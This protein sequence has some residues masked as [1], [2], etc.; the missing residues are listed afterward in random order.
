MKIR[1][2]VVYSMVFVVLGFS[3]PA[4]AQARQSTAKTSTS[5]QASPEKKTDA[6]SLDDTADWIKNALATSGFVT[7]TA[8]GDGWHSVH[9][10]RNTLHN[11][12]LCEFVFNDESDHEETYSAGGSDRSIERYVITIN[13]ENIDPA[14][15]KLS[16][17]AP[18][19]GQAGH[20]SAWG[21]SVFMQTTDLS[22]TILRSKRTSQTSK[23]TETQPDVHDRGYSIMISE[24]EIGERLVKALSH[25]V[26]LCG[27]KHSAF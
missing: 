22:E 4:S 18:G 19:S 17:N 26:E 23:G 3:L 15:V 12:N 11:R 20:W 21:Y 6:P 10:I 9:N 13:L 8:D 25:A 2:A 5:K 14:S 24:K 7:R 16:E 27:G 1:N